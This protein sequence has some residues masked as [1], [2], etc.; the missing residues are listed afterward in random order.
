MYSPVLT[1]SVTA[2][3]FAF[4]ENN[5]HGCLIFNV[6]CV[7]HRK[8]ICD[9]VRPLTTVSRLQMNDLA[10]MQNRPRV[11]DKASTCKP[12]V[13]ARSTAW[14]ER[15]TRRGGGQCHCVCRIACR[16]YVSVVFTL[17]LI[18]NE[19]LRLISEWQGKSTDIITLIKGS[20]PRML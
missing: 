4:N 6:L 3:N 11:W 2:G 9:P 1:L 20:P 16:S 12:V 13:C 19:E 18:R 17:R 10:K 7:L 15:R 5:K 8:C 14:L